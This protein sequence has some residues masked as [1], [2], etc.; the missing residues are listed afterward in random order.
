MCFEVEKKRIEVKIE[1]ICR[2]KD[3]RIGGINSLYFSLVIHEY[4]IYIYI[5]TQKPI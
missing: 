5:Y 3:K 4:N 2:E 1:G